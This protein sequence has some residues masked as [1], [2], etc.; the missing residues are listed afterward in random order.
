MRIKTEQQIKTELDC[1]VKAIC[2]LFL[3]NPY[4]FFSGASS[5]TIGMAANALYSYA[6]PSNKHFWRKVIAEAKQQGLLPV[7][8]CAYVAEMVAAEQ[9]L[10]NKGQIK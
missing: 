6:L 4:M 7:R 8:S 3:L 5:S 2:E 10:M 9:R 1:G